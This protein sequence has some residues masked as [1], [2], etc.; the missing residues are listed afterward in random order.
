MKVRKWRS[1]RLR[2]P[3][4]QGRGWDEEQNDVDGGRGGG[5]SGGSGGERGIV[6][7]VR[8][9]LWGSLR[10]LTGTGARRGVIGGGRARG[11]YNTLPLPGMQVKRVEVKRGRTLQQAESS[12]RW[13]GARNSMVG[14]YGN[15][16]RDD[17]DADNRYGNAA[18]VGRRRAVSGPFG[19]G[20]G[21]GW[22]SNIQST[23]QEMQKVQDRGAGGRHGSVS[24]ASSN[25]PSVGAVRKRSVGIPV[26]GF[27]ISPP[28]SKN[29][30]LQNATDASDLFNMWDD[31]PLRETGNPRVVS[32]GY[33]GYRAK[34]GYDTKVFSGLVKKENLNTNLMTAGISPQIRQ[35]HN[36]GSRNGEMVDADQGLPKRQHWWKEWMRE[37][38]QGILTEEK[39]RLDVFHGGGSGVTK[40]R[41]DAALGVVPP[42]GSPRRA[43]SVDRCGGDSNGLKFYM[44]GARNE[45]RDRKSV[46]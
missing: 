8:N 27:D 19:Y 26:V 44:R 39:N 1:G 13:G 24:T 38:K 21:S 41:V 16:M 36:E 22:G 33:G 20:V 23:R 14:K 17:Y 2:H 6:E 35:Q 5:G 18:V 43:G 9:V 31:I 7:T 34:V 30:Q 29:N 45:A 46:V 40:P 11:S 4:I 3:Q 28:M 32:G 25:M 37:N 15:G 10:G 42:V 12:G